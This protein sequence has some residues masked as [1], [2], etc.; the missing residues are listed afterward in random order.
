[1][2][3]I[4]LVRC[5]TLSFI[6]SVFQD[7]T[8]AKLP[9]KNLDYLVAERID[10]NKNYRYIEICVSNPFFS[11]SLAATKETLIKK[12]NWIVQLFL[13]CPCIATTWTKV[14]W[15]GVHVKAIDEMNTLAR[16]YGKGN[17][18]ITSAQKKS[19]RRIDMFSWI[20]CR[21]S[22][23]LEDVKTQEEEPV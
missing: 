2:Q 12:K 18:K 3:W 21:F 9:D 1:M 11:P 13:V 16:D 19:D 14:Q 17:A 10:K 20:T 6:F 23:G 7:S 4:K 5:F 22:S 15:S 8:F